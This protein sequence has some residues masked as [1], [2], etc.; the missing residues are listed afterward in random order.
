MLQVSWGGEVVKRIEREFGINA[1]CLKDL[2]ELEALEPIKKA[3]F[4]SVFIC[5]YQND[6]VA[7]IKKKADEI[8]LVVEF[9]HAPFKGINN[10]WI[11][12]VNYLEIFSQMVESLDSAA[13]NGIEA[14]VIHVS[15]GW[16]APPVN[17][18][19]F[20]RFDELVRYAEKKGVKLVFEN[21]RMTGN[22]AC[23]VDRYE[24]LSHVMFCYDCGHEHCY[25]KTVRWM[26][27]FTTRVFCTHVHDNPGRSFEDRVNDFDWHML[28]FDGT[29]D[30]ARMMRELDSYGYSGRI[31]LE[32][33][34]CKPEYEK[35]T[36]EEFLAECYQR[37]GRLS[38]MT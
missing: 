20:L 22:L 13:N 27:I 10:M 29:C 9:I 35:W 1:D 21:L 33:T 14:V 36:A 3:G 8:G 37:I 34:Q 28:P 15:S 16:Q 26:D 30:Y 31:T 12:G 17:D 2:S 6:A 5:A 24:K 18:L 23:L 32:V 4:K 19:G 7:A 11:P 38:K 25:T